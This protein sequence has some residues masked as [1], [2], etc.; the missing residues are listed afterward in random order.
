MFGCCRACG[1]RTFNQK[2]VPENVNAPGDVKRLCGAGW[3]RRRRGLDSARRFGFADR[4]EV[5]P[6]AHAPH[7]AVAIQV[8]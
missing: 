8:A 4:S 3:S 1:V 2:E 5:A 6:G 7:R